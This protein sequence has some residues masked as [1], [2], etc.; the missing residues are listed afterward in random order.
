MRPPRFADW[1]LKLLVRRGTAHDVIG[2]L[3][4]EFFEF[5]L[6]ELGSR[7]ARAWYWRQVLGV[8][9]RYGLLLG[10]GRAFAPRF[11]DSV[12]GSTNRGSIRASLLMDVRYS[13]RGLLRFPGFSI[14]AVLILAMG[15]GA[16]STVFGAVYGV[17]LRPPPYERPEE[18]VVVGGSLLGIGSP[19]LAASGSEYLDYRE[20]AEA[21]SDLAALWP[22]RVNLTGGEKPVRVE[23]VGTTSNL[24]S[25]LGVSPVLGRD[26]REDDAGGNI[27]YVAIISHNAWQTLF[28]GAADVIGRTV[29]MDGDPI[30]IIGVMP[31]GFKN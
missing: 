24:F 20:Q 1:V 23:S 7:R 6:S 19:T 13:F 31:Q 12:D 30:T 26:F 21:F 2:D 14:T 15:I 22:T 28:D 27:G 3:H 29:K 9:P 4:E 18:L 17:L 5:Q 10:F 16:I 8:L 25:L 11:H